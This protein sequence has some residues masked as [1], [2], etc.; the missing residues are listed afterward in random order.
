MGLFE[1]LTATLVG[2]DPLSDEAGE[3]VALALALAD[4]GDFA[5]A[6]HRLVA[7]AD[8]HPRVP[9]IWVALGEV[10]ARGGHDEGAVTAFGRAVDLSTDAIDGWLGL[11]EAL[12]RLRRPDPAGDA[13]RRVLAST[14]DP[15]RRARAHTGR[16]KLA[17]EAGRFAKAARE[18]RKAAQL[19]PDDLAVAAD[20]G[21]ALMAA[22]E[23]DGWQWL[24]RAAQAPGADA[25]LVAEAASVSPK[26]DAAESLLRSALAGTSEGHENGRRTAARLRSALARHM[27]DDGRIPAAIELARQALVESGTI[28]GDSSRVLDEVDASED[29][30]VLAGWRHVCTRAGDFREALRTAAREQELGVSP[31]PEVMIALALGAHD[32]DALARAAGAL[33]P[34]HPMHAALQA[35]LDGNA[36]DDHLARLGALAP[37]A[38]ARGFVAAAA[39]PG[40]PPVGNLFALLEFARDLAARAPELRALLPLA[41][42]AV[43]AFDRPLLVAVMGEF[44]AGKSSFV[45]ALCGEEVAPVGVT[46]TTATINV[47]RYGPPGGRVL[48]HDGRAQDLTAA[49]VA[50]FLSG[51]GAQEAAA[52]RTVEV[53]FPLEFLRRVEIVDTPG[54]NALRPEH[55][56]VARGFLIEADAIVWVF[57]AGQA[58]KATER[59]ALALAHAADKRVLGVLNKAD[60]IDAPDLVAVLAA[61]QAALADMLE[62]LLPLSA[63]R[64]LVARRAGDAAAVADSGLPAVMAALE[65]RFF[66]D[67]RTLKRRTALLVLERFVAEARALVPTQTDQGR[68]IEIRRQALDEHEE[69]FLGALASER[70]ALRARL[71][72]AFRQAA[73]EVLEFVRPAR[74]PFVERRAETADEELLFELLDDAVAVASGETRKALDAVTAGGPA[75][76]IDMAIERFR[77][78]VRGVLAGGLVERVLAEELPAP[79]G[80]ADQASFARAL[81]RRLPDADAELFMPL[82]AEAR[83]AYGRARAELER[84]ALWAEMRRLVDDARLSCPLAALADAVQALAAVPPA[85]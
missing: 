28:A 33:A 17:Y 69:A 60:Q 41:A 35:F 56:R 13:F 59:D 47:T 26:R 72:Q 29:P 32:R 79:G 55:E 65:D 23:P 75:I 49:G 7:I 14:S 10:R 1:R 81:T 52:V 85:P 43:E 27:A 12:V 78:Y 18:L 57:A 25:V 20:L 8:A 63:R 39:S 73:G 70:L 53:F 83:A 21:R 61:V 42:R 15:S 34:E 71:D 62:A 45:N 38:E 9:A 3:E 44:N 4:R 76:P 16:G 84:E 50:P 64:A 40:A 68:S 22:G 74:W 54:L 58:A 82:A 66:R 6:E 2:G 30:A 48:Y 5:G 37:G 80:R 77:A 67:A 24:L 51:L 11:G 31:D 46:P 19:A 36:S